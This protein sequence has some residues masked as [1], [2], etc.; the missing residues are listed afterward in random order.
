VIYETN[1]GRVELLEQQDGTKVERPCKQGR[2]GMISYGT[3]RSRISAIPK[4]KPQKYADWSE[5][6]WRWYA[7]VSVLSRSG[8]VGRETVLA[9]LGYKTNYSMRGFGD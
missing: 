3:V 4:S 7:P 9:I 5:V 6:W 1:S 8:F 2:G